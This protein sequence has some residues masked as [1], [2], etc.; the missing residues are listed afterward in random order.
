MGESR[1]VEE[2]RTTASQAAAFSYTSDFDHQA[3]WDPNT[4]SARRITEPPVDVGSRFALEVRMGPR[5]IP[6]E[7]RVTILEPPHRV[8]LVGEGR[9]IWSEDDI[10]FRPDGSTTVVRY[11]ARIRLGGLLGL[12]QP[13]LGRQMRRIGTEAAAGLARELDRLAVEQA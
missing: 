4:I 10:S 12:I 3:D 8:V 5:S 9:G 1:L 2:V 7:Y 13:L 6:M 11:E